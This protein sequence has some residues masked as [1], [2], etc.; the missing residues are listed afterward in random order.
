MNFN[1]AMSSFVC[2]S[3]VETVVYSYKYEFQGK[4]NI[5]KITCEKFQAPKIF[6]GG[7]LKVNTWCKKHFLFSQF[8]LKMYK[9][10]QKY[11]SGGDISV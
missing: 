11:F 1:I 6:W 4:V 2:C 8:L 3:L 9:N 5:Y 7:K 10:H